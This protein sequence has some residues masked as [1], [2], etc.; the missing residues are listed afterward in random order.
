SR[1]RRLG[2]PGEARFEGKGVAFCAT[3]DAPL[4]KGKEVVVV[5]G[6]NSG[7]ESVVDL[8]PYASK[9]YLLHRGSALKGDPVTEERIRKHPKVTVILNAETEEIVGEMMVGGTRYRDAVTGTVHTLAAQGVFVEIGSVPNSEMVADLVKLND[10]KEIVVDHRT[11]QTSAAGIWAAGDVADCR[12]KQNNISAG[13][14]VKAVL[15]MYETLKA[16]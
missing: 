4:F 5:G 3:C 13:D 10:W 15:N 6:G 11:Q 9:V 1:R 16:A 2:V 14:A 7:L 12:Y 8:I